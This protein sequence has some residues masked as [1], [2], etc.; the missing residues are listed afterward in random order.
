MKV[1]LARE[2]ES[3][4]GNYRGRLARAA[5]RSRSVLQNFRHLVQTPIFDVEDAAF[6][7]IRFENEAVVPQRG[8]PDGDAGCDLPFHQHGARNPNR[9]RVKNSLLI[10]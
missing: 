9:A 2:Q 8:L 1:S 3:A 4:A 6:A 10:H 5:A 7:F